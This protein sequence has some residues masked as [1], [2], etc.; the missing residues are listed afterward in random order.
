MDGGREAGE[1]RGVE[2][3]V[4]A[5]GARDLEGVER[6]GAGVVGEAALDEALKFDDAVEGVG[7]A[8]GDEVAAVGVGLGDEFAL[9]GFEHL[10][11]VPAGAEDVEE[12][13][14]WEA[15]CV[16]GGG[17]PPADPA[18]ACF[19][20]GVLPSEGDVAP[21]GLLVFVGRGYDDVTYHN[22][23][24]EAGDGG[25]DGGPREKKEAND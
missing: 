25:D 12:V 15:G 17:V 20:G 3:L 23:G 1:G 4:D 24:D 18:P 13:D 7:V 2:G 16:G 14:G 11:G 9:D 22:E 6:A 8:R 5:P 10:R 21:L 19:L